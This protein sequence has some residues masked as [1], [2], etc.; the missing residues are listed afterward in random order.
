MDSGKMIPELSERVQL[1][2]VKLQDSIS[3]KK[4]LSGHAIPSPE[5]Q[6]RCKAV[7]LDNLALT[8]APRAPPACAAL[9]VTPTP[10]LCPAGD[11]A[12]PH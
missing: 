4:T 9:Q 11:A 3:G 5:S 1:D 10:A 2:D 12:W 7:G 6:V 8:A